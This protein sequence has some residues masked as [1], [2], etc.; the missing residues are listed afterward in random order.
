MNKES[1]KTLIAALS[2]FIDEIKDCYSAVEVYS[3]DS[4]HKPTKTEYWSSVIA[5]IDNGETHLLSKLGK[6]CKNIDR[7]KQAG[8]LL[9]ALLKNPLFVVNYGQKDSK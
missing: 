7:H 3:S 5:L 4:K 8:L 6:D 2:P 9:V 1:F